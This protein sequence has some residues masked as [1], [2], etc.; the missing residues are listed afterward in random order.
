MEPSTTNFV[1]ALWPLWLL[2]I[3]V[4]VG[5]SIFEGKIGNKTGDKPENPVDLNVF[6]RKPYLFDTNSEFA[7]YKILDELFGNSY[8]IFAQ[9]N[10]SHLIQPKKSTKWE[11]R[12]DRSRI[13]R[14]SADFVICDRQTVVPKL[15]IELD[16]YVH[17]YSSKEKRD[18]FIDEIAEI[19]G[20][21]I[22]HLKT[23]NFNKEFV[24]TEVSKK[25]GILSK[26]IWHQ[27][28]ESDLR[29]SIGDGKRNARDCIM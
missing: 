10:Y 27:N 18:K 1:I 11:E 22:L 17:N 5:K 25:L 16:G 2:F 21:P 6:E 3:V 9:V 23:N 7:L 19:A 29:K 8:R 14:K 13:D 26:K 15:I 24:K 20:L 28:E 12:R 4:A